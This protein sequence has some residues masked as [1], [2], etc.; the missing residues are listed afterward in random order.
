MKT[1]RIVGAG[2]LM[3]ALVFFALKAPA[4]IT[5]GPVSGGVNPTGNGSGLTNL[6]F[7]NITGGYAL[8][9]FVA[10]NGNDSTAVRG[11]L[12]PFATPKAAVQAAQVGDTVHIW[13][14]LY[15]NQIQILSNGVNLDA[16]GTVTISNF[17]DDT[18]NGSWGHLL[19]DS[20][21]PVTNRITGKMNLY[22]NIGTNVSV[23]TT[24]FGTNK[25]PTFLGSTNFLDGVSLTN[26]LSS[27]RW[28]FGTCTIEDHNS[29]AGRR[30]FDILGCTNAMIDFDEI[31]PGTNVVT[32]VTN[33]QTWSYPQYTNVDDAIVWGFGDL[34]MTGKKIGPMFQYGTWS[35]GPSDSIIHTNNYFLLCPDIESKIYTSTAPTNTPAMDAVYRTWITTDWL[36][37]SNAYA[38]Q[39]ASFYGGYNYLTFQKIS[40]DKAALNSAWG[41]VQVGGTA[42]VWLTGHKITA[43][44]GFWI[45]T[46]ANGST[47]GSPSVHAAVLEY[48]ATASGVS[49]T[50]GFLF[51]GQQRVDIEGGDVHVSSGIPVFYNNATGGGGL[52][53]NG[54]VYLKNMTIDNSAAGGTTNYTVI[55][56][57]NGIYL[58]NCRIIAPPSTTNLYSATG[59]NI[60]IYGM[61]MVNNST[62]VNVTNNTGGTIV[63]NANVK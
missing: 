61:L 63:T 13:A 55:I 36:H 47:N 11:G 7:T 28:S 60:G 52:T 25:H 21:N 33:S 54:Q 20:N 38:S 35:A 5:T 48:D 49:A 42:N 31:I 53:N 14:G 34:N 9:L 40:D 18:V 17:V 59:Q 22:F 62:S 27:V 15:T 37:C 56:D 50:G 23:V 30:V 26:P 29:V 8:N 3:L 2:V 43:N 24:G 4:P 12:N 10:T 39:C 1:P 41:C 44:G 57:T 51:Q 6:T 45:N 16:I 46:P 58:D 19:D 32:Y